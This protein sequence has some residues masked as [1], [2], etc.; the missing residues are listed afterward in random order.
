MATN[1]L[2]KK[3]ERAEKLRQQIRDERIKQRSLALEQSEAMQSAQLDDEIA[4]L[5]AELEA[6]KAATLAIKKTP[7]P[8]FDTADLAERQA[9]SAKRVAE[10]T[11]KT[12]KEN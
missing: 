3:Q 5:G 9:E 2:Q 7:V 4:R 10:S 1:D 12:G 6:E 11:T 8:V